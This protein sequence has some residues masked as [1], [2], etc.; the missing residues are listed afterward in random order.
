MQFLAA[1]WSLV[2]V[3]L[4]AFVTTGVMSRINPTSAM[5]STSATASGRRPWSTLSRTLPIPRTW[6]INLLTPLVFLLSLV[7]FAVLIVLVTLEMVNGINLKPATASGR[8]PQSTLGRLL[9]IPRTWF[10]NARNALVFLRS[11]GEW[12]RHVGHV[13]SLRRGWINWNRTVTSRPS[14]VAYPVDEHALSECLKQQPSRKVRIVGSGHS[15]ND[16][17][18]TPELLISLD[19]YRLGSGT[20]WELLRKDAQGGTVRVSA[21]MRLRDLGRVLLEAG[22][23]VPVLGSADAQTLGGLMATDVHGTGRDHGF[24]SEQVVALRIMDAQ[25]EAREF[26][27]DATSPDERDTFRAALSGLGACGIITQLELEC[28]PHFHLEK[29]GTFMQREEVDATL[30]TLVDTHAHLSLYELAGAELENVR[31]NI[32]TPTSQ[33]PPSKMHVQR[34]YAELGELF[35][36]GFLFELAFVWLAQRK[37]ITTGVFSLLKWMTRKFHTLVQPAGIAFTRTLYFLHDE[38]EY[39]VPYGHYRACMAE[40]RQMLERERFMTL[41]EVRFTPPLKTVALIGPGGDDAQR[42]CF[43]GLTPT[44]SYG[45]KELDR[46]FSLAADILQRHGGQVHMGKN[47]SNVDARRMLRMHGEKFLRFQQ[48]RDRQDP[49]RRFSNAFTER[50]LGP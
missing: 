12:V 21:G 45:R 13:R 19:N 28:V 34:M 32:W 20:E 23:A 17:P 33:P 36:T 16:S 11:N 18:A 5:A 2:F 25:G 38:L 6:V 26:R 27:R 31:L 3:V 4:I 50:V 40:L 44:L 1:H 42:T 15:F 8:R 48:I 39:G 14:Q 43:I 7:V 30:D 24:L 41:I 10:I 9:R 29:L 49:H 37:T 22:L 46:V 47:M 35:V